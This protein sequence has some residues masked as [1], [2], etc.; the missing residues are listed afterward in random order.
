MYVGGVGE[1]VEARGGMVWGG[2][3]RCGGRDVVGGELAAILPL[4]RPVH[5]EEA[6]QEEVM[7]E[8]SC[9]L[10]LSRL[11]EEIQVNSLEHSV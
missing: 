10:S 6:S 4:F 11:E 5:V 3:G 9:E 7:Q 8:D 1:G 2:V